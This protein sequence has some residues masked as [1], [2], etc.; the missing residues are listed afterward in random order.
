MLV[1][2]LVITTRALKALVLITSNYL[3]PAGPSIPPTVALLGPLI[4]GY[5][6]QGPP[7]N[8]NFIKK[9]RYYGALRAPK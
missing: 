8:R 5:G 7:L 1:T 4:G 9:F 6:G 3:G 2:L